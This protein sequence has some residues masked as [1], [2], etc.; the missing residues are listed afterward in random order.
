MNQYLKSN[1][2]SF[3]F[4]MIR[5][6]LVILFRAN[7]HVLLLSHPF[8]TKQDCG[9]VLDRLKTYKGVHGHK[10]LS[11]LTFEPTSSRVPIKKNERMMRFEHF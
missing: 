7:L 9:Y 2:N 3:Q 11:P 1:P 8:F 5:G 4:V 6:P 10:G